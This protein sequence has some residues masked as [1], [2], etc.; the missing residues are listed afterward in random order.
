V[1][2]ASAIALYWAV[3]L[4]VVIAVRRELGRRSVGG[5]TSRA[6]DVRL[7]IA[8]AVTVLTTVVLTVLR[9]RSGG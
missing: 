5:T 9:L 6:A 1:T 3:L 2:A 4:I 7:H 8:L